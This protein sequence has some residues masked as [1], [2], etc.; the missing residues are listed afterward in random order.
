MT[1]ERDERGFTLIEII[2]TVV[3]MA[4]LL[5]LAVLALRHF[6]LTRSLTAAT[7]SVVTQLRS[8]QERVVSESW[9]YVYGVRFDIDGGRWWLVRYDPVNPGPGDDTCQVVETGT[10]GDGV[11][12]RSASF[13]SDALITDF[14]RSSVGANPDDAFALFYSRGSATNGT[15]TLE[16]KQVN[17][18]KTI[19]VDGITGRVTKS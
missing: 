14:C 18:T 19:S 11:V 5:S 15:V 12:V 10:Y 7:D 8:T 13:A 3:I 1:R 9:P 2:S 4:I 6:W 16:Q 17:K